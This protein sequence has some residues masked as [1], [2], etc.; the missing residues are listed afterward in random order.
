MKVNNT[1]LT[2]G[3]H[4]DISSSNHYTCIYVCVCVCIGTYLEDVVGSIGC[5]NNY[6]EYVVHITEEEVYSLQKKC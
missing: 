4:P 5:I 6:I 1:C 2:L 3:A